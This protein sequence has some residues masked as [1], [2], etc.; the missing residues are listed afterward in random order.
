MAT[1]LE[2]YEV[3]PYG[4]KPDRSKQGGDHA[5]LTKWLRN[6]FAHG[7]WDYDKNNGKHRETRELMEELFPEVCKSEPGFPTPI[8]SI[9]EPL[10]DGVLSYIRTVT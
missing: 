6:R 9:L 10:K 1:I 4:K 7:D 8:D 3:V 5:E 2:V